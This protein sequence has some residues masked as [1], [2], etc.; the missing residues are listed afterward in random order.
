MRCWQPLQFQERTAALRLDFASGV[1]GGLGLGRLGLLGWGRACCSASGGPWWQASREQQPDQLPA[2]AGSRSA[3]SWAAGTAP[4]PSPSPGDAPAR[5]CQRGPHRL[6]CQC[7]REMGALFGVAVQISGYH[8]CYGKVHDLILVNTGV[9]PTLQK[10]GQ[11]K[12]GGRQDIH[13]TNKDRV[14]SEI[15]RCG[16]RNA[17][18]CR[19]L[20]RCPSI[21]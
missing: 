12:D 16:H 4:H 21:T 3:R 20:G 11:V 10:T 13:Q 6:C 15:G 17:T 9:A 5:S 19:A 8:R 18:P 7:S 14:A 2:W 1:P